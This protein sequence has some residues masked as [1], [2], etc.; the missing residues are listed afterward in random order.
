M[1]GAFFLNILETGLS[2]AAAVLVYQALGCMIRVRKK[3]W[4]EGVLL[5]CC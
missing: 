4:C 3:R 2:V 5:V 1:N